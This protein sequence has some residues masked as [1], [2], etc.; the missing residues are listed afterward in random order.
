MYLTKKSKFSDIKNIVLQS[1][2]MW[3]IGDLLNKIGFIL[4]FMSNISVIIHFKSLNL[5]EVERNGFNLI[6][7]VL[8]KDDGRS[9]YSARPYH[10]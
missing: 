10:H 1:S 2:R 8:V 9:W 7:I 6:S 4:I 3:V 5:L